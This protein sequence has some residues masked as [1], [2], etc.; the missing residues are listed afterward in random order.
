M[1][2]KLMLFSMIIKPS[3]KPSQV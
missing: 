1:S 3:T 2:L